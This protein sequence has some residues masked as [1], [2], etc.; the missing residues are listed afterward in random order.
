MSRSRIKSKSGHLPKA[1]QNIPSLAQLRRDGRAAS[2]RIAS[3]EGIIQRARRR[4]LVEWI[5]QS[6]RLWFASE[7]HGLRGADFL[8][9][10]TDIG[11]G[12]RSVAYRL[13][14]LHMY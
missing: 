6:E 4:T 2:R 13:L 11:I 8:S 7:L 5:D 10:A 12:H 1:N 14:K 3:T 9:F